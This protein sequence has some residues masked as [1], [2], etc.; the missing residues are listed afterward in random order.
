MQFL[1]LRPYIAL[2]LEEIR[3]IDEWRMRDVGRA[4]D[5]ALG[6][7]PESHRPEFG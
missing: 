7:D 1:E 2:L 5:Q 6:D 4:L 3:S